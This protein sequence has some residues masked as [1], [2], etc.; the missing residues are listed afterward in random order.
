LANWI[1]SPN[2]PFFARAM[3]NKRWAQFFGRG[4]V[5]PVDDMH[6]DNPATHPEL[7]QAMTEQFKKH[8]YDLKYLVKAIAMSEAYQ[9]T[10]KPFQGNESDA[11][12]FSHSYVRTLTPEQLYD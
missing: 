7:L 9:R 6:D 2:N 1:S 12:L 3:V 11:E 8:N 4:L 5:N 10:S